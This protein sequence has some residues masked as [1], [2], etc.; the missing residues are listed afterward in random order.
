M[1]KANMYYYKYYSLASYPCVLHS[2]WQIKDFL[3]TNFHN[4]SP[5]DKDNTLPCHWPIYILNFF[6]FV[7]G[8]WIETLIWSDFEWLK[9]FSFRRDAHYNVECPWKQGDWEMRDLMFPFWQYAM[10]YKTSQIKC[11]SIYINIDNL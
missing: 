11:V 9:G 10:S 4:C 6:K 2:H 8:S 7:P 5:I 1:F 3:K